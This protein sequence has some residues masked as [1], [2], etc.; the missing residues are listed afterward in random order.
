MLFGKI[1][2]PAQRQRRARFFAQTAAHTEQVKGF[3]GHAFTIQQ[4]ISGDKIG[5]GEIDWTHFVRC[6]AAWYREIHQ[7]M[8]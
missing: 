4:G 1:E 7:N 3:R 2:Q 5:F 8:R 6:K